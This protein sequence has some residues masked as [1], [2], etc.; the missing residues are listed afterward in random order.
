MEGHEGANLGKKCRKCQLD[1]VGKHMAVHG[2]NTTRWYHPQCLQCIT[3]HKVIVAGEKYTVEKE[4]P[5][6]GDCFAT[7]EAVSK[8]PRGGGFKS[9]PSDARG[10]VWQMAQ[11]IEAANPP[12]QT[13]G[14]PK[15]DVEGVRCEGIRL[16]FCCVVG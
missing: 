15:K 3:C 4:G 2:F 12:Q 5:K 8:S 1:I 10:V 16:V 14:P 9:K 13:Q 6:C 11:A 7:W